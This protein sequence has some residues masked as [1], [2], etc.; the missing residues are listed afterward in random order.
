MFADQL[1]KSHSNS[2]THLDWLIDWLICW[3]TCGLIDWLIDWLVEWLID[4]LICWMISTSF[5]LT[6][7]ADEL[8]KTHR[9]Y[10]I[11]ELD[12]QR[13]LKRY[14]PDLTQDQ[15]SVLE[16]SIKRIIMRTIYGTDYYYYQGFHDIAITVHLVLADEDRTCVSR[17]P[18]WHCPSSLGEQSDEWIVHAFEKNTKKNHSRGHFIL[19]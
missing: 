18:T 10:N 3:L 2:T 5:Y 4:W 14:P 17:L 19:S 1:M 16:S 13:L 12:V 6:F 7:S 8:L 9:D 11:V 15:R